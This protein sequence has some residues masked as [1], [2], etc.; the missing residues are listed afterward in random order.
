MKLSREEALED[1][2]QHAPKS[3]EEK[4]AFCS[5]WLSRTIMGPGI[6]VKLFLP[7][8][9]P[10]RE[11]GC[12]LPGG[13][14][15]FQ[16]TLPDTASADPLRSPRAPAGAGRAI[17]GAAGASS[18]G[19]CAGSSARPR[20]AAAA[21]ALSLPSQPPER[22]C[23]PGTAE[24]RPPPVSKQILRW[25]ERPLARRVPSVPSG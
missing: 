8:A 6:R 5:C 22:G 25:G 11:T 1:G 15:W 9:D 16:S 10:K 18:P 23:G 13:W 3:E 14:E 4:N 17:S 21:C 20:A 7:A 19:H 2:P 24:R 12:L